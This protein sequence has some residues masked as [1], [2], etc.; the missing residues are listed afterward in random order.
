MNNTEFKDKVDQILEMVGNLLVCKN[1]AYSGK[2]DVLSNFNN[3]IGH[4]ILGI[5]IRMSDK[6]M[7]LK[8][9]LNAKGLDI[10]VSY[11]DE[12][13]RDTVADLIGYGV[14]FLIVNDSLEED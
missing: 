10:D 5:A 7:R 14:L 8:T 3:G 12:S 2:D 13:I 6:M 9:L 4:P 11:G 1:N